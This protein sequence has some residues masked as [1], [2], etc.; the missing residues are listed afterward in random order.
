MEIRNFWAA[1]LRQDRE[2]LAGFFWEDAVI[3]WHNTNECF[4]AAEFIQA[5]CGYPGRWDGKLE[6]VI[7]LGDQVITVTHVYNKEG[8]VSCHAVSFF[9]IREDKILSVDEY[10]GD[11]GPPPRW[12]QAMRLGRTIVAG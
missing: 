10:W 12:R 5:N 7:E 8:T 11:D 3:N 9:R 1:V 2:A 4:T 6:R